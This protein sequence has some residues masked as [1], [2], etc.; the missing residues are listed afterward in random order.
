LR[1]LV[2]CLAVVAACG[3]DDTPAEKSMRVTA[4]PKARLAV[5]A[6]AGI[7]L[8]VRQSGAGEVKVEGEWGAI[9]VKTE[10]PVNIEAACAGGLVETRGGNLRCALRGTISRSLQLRAYRAKALHLELTDAY[11]GLVNLATETGGIVVPKDPRFAGR[12]EGQ[13]KAIIGFVGKRW[14]GEELKGADKKPG[15]WATAPEGT[16]AL[17]FAKR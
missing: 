17:A 10:G 8:V 15:I 11:R 16:V 3:G 12:A 4:A 2:A 13:G 9:T 6:P 14:E 7:E 1:S 5:A